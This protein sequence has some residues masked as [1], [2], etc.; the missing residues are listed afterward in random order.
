MC[1][2]FQAKALSLQEGNTPLHLACD[3]GFSEVVKKI[4]RK[5]DSS[6][7]AKNQ[8]CRFTEHHVCN[9]SLPSGVGLLK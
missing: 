6:I 5:S 4:L 2:T 9:Y 3:K 8:V 7:N 1:N